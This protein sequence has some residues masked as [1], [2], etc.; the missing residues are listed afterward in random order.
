M[1]V[2]AEVAKEVGAEAAAAASAE[3]G[4]AAPPP[5]AP[6]LPEEQ[7]P[8]APPD[9]EHDEERRRMVAALWGRL[10]ALGGRAGVS[11]HDDAMAFHEAALL[12]PLSAGERALAKSDLR[13]FWTLRCQ[14]VSPTPG[15]PP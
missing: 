10:E 6:A 2:D 7:L 9:P 1:N 15:A 4:Q 14:S 12:V 3:T 5:C 11:P 8:W 13:V